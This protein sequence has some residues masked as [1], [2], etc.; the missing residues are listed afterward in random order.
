MR[1][2]SEPTPRTE[3]GSVNNSRRSSLQDAYTFEERCGDDDVLIE[4]AD[5]RS[6]LGIWSKRIEVTTHTHTHTMM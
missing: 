2:T 4:D 6:A 5:S 1:R 3:I